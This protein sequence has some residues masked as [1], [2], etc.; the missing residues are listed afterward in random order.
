MY[1]YVFIDVYEYS[2]IPYAVSSSRCR[3]SYTMPVPQQRIEFGRFNACE[4]S[5]GPMFE[6][7]DL[8]LKML[9]SA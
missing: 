6:A 5:D 9:P 4:G 7:C 8:T 2:Y 3:R 1:I